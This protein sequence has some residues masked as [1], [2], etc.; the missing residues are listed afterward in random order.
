[1][2]MAIRGSLAYFFNVL[3]IYHTVQLQRGDAT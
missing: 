2:P 1:M 3:L